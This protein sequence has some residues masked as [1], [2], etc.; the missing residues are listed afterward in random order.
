[1]L[2]YHLWM[3]TGRAWASFI[4][5]SSLPLQGN[6]YPPILQGRRSIG[7]HSPP[8]RRPDPPPTPGRSFA[9][10]LFRVSRGQIWRCQSRHRRRRVAFQ[11]MRAHRARGQHGSIVSPNGTNLFCFFVVFTPCRP[12]H[13]GSVWVLRVISLFLTNTVSPFASAA[14]TNCLTGEI[15]LDP[16]RRRL[17]AS[18]H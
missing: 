7:P 1:M 13:Q 18:W 16:K 6:I 14:S 15:S 5:K 8:T 11:E 3:G 12:R 10:C 17:Q 2:Q 9:A 4:V